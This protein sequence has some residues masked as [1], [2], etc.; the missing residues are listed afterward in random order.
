ARALELNHANPAR[1][2]GRESVAVAERGSVLS[3]RVA[4]GEDRAPLRGGHLR[5]VDG[6]RH[7]FDG[8][9]H[10]LSASTPKRS[11]ADSIA[12]HAARPRPQM[13][14]SFITKP[15]SRSNWTSRP[16]AAASWRLRAMRSSASS[17]RTVPT[18]QGTHW[19][20]DSSRKKR[21]MRS[22]MAGRSTVSSKA[23]TT[24]EPRVVLLAR[25]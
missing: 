7:L 2:L 13:E 15:T 6:D 19:P 22:R 14:E 17:W 16:V 24:P 18:R 21:A 1:I 25:A 11:I 23:N 4:G 10:L 3:R 9:V 5:A 12:V 20:Q 8:R